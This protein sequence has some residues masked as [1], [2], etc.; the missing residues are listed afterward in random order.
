[1]GRTSASAVVGVD[2]HAR[3]P[4]RRRPREVVGCMRP[5]CARSR[6]RQAVSMSSALATP[7]SYSA[8]GLHRQRTDEP[9]V[10]KPA[11]SLFHHDS[12][13]ADRLREVACHRQSSRRSC[14]DRGRARTGASVGTGEKKCVPTT[15]SGRRVRRRWSYRDRRVVS[16]ALHRPFAH[17][18]EMAEHLCLDRPALEDGPHSR[19]RHVGH[20]DG[21]SV[22]VECD[23][24]RC[25]SG[26][27]DRPCHEPGEPILE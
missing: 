4:Q 16:R 18:V 6:R 20:S 26:A 1:V 7:L 9:V 5:R 23:R 22:V 3:V 15:D 10:T 19:G 27:T 17:L 21:R 25:C 24:G 13:L 2:V 12:R 8:N 14:G 11:T